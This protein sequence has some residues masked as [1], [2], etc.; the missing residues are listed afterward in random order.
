MPQAYAGLIPV[1][2][3]VRGGVPLPPGFVGPWPVMT[4]GE[5]FRCVSRVAGPAS[6][7][8]YGLARLGYRGAVDISVP[9]P[10]FTQLTPDL[11]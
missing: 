8:H 2:Y 10:S 11:Q 5:L 4:T 3:G 1:P 7:Q 9:K 6:M